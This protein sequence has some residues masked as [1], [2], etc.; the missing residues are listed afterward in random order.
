MK[1][2]GAYKHHIIISLILGLMVLGLVFGLIFPELLEAGVDW[3]VCRQSI[4]LRN[5]MPN[6]IVIDQAKDLLPLKCKAE[7]IEV[8]YKDID[9]AEKEIAD[10]MA[11]CWHLFGEGRYSIFPPT[12]GVFPESYCV[13]CARIHFDEDVKD[14]YRWQTPEGYREDFYVLSYLAETEYENTGKTYSDYFWK[15][16]GMGRPE[17]FKLPESSEDDDWGFRNYIDPNHDLIIGIY[18]NTGS[19]FKEWVPIIGDNGFYS[20]LFYYQPEI[21]ELDCK[22]EGIPA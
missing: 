4:Y 19:H 18:F 20:L 1:K 3:E 8:D 9:R 14:F 17:G 7:V 6:Y 5:S 15:T 16:G 21:D 11:A 13:P 10:T 22:F 2:R 12:R